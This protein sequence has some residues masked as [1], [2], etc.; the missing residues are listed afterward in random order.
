MSP[1]SVVHIFRSRGIAATPGFS[2]F[3]TPWAGMKATA[4]DTFQRTQQSGSLG[5][6]VYYPGSNA[7]SSTSDSDFWL[8]TGTYKFSVIQEANS[9]K[10]IVS[11]QLDAVTKSTH[12]GYA[13]AQTMNAYS[14]VTGIAVTAGLKVVRFTNPTKNASSSGYGMFLQTAAFIRTGA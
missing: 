13:A 2:I 9:N 10:A 7:Q 3:L 1:T 5:G 11:V 8:D 4:G 6:G 14:E 12:D